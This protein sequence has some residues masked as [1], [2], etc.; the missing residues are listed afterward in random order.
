M[1]LMEKGIRRHYNASVVGKGILS[2]QHYNADRRPHYNV[3]MDAILR[4]IVMS[5]GKGIT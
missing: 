5:L 4:S 3:L 1:M 2:A